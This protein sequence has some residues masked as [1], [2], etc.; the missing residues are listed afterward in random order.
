MFAEDADLDAAVW[1]TRFLIDAHATTN[2]DLRAFFAREDIFNLR[3]RMRN[4]KSSKARDL[5]SG[6]A[7]LALHNFYVS[8]GTRFDATH[9][10]LDSLERDL[11]EAGA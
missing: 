3:E 11:P 2:G 1:N 6:L 4:L 7:N 8:F 5:M 10:L 9:Q